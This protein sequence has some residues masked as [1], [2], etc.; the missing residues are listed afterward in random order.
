MLLLGGHETRRNLIGNGMYTLLQHAEAMAQLQDEPEIIR[1]AVEELLRF[2]SPIQYT[3][4]IVRQEMELDGA[5]VRPGELLLFMLGAANRD[6]RQFNDAD[7]MDLKRLNN[8]HL[9]FGAGAHFCIGNQLAR[10]EGQAAI[11]RLVQ[12]FPRMKLTSQRPEW[13][14]NFDFRGLRALPVMV[15]RVASPSD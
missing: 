10:L 1:T 9:A 7:R 11:L 4:R 13:A 2:E 14:P 12:E 6:P 5:Q 15:S 8:S 3:G